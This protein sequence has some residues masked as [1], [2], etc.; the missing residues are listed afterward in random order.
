MNTLLA[1]HVD[2]V[3]NP[4][5]NVLNMRMKV[6]QPLHQGSKQR[7]A[8]SIRVSVSTGGEVGSNDQ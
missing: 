4:S 1:G 7:A 2:V 6:I 5:A 3:W 8:D